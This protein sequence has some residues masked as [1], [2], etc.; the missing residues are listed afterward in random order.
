LLDGTAASF[1]DNQAAVGPRHSRDEEFIYEAIVMLAD[2]SS[3]P[4]QWDEVS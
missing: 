3:I 2:G 4:Q 1:C